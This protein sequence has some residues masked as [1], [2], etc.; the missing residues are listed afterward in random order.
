MPADFIELIISVDFSLLK[1]LQ[2]FS[3]ASSS[4]KL[5]SSSSSSF[6]QKEAKSDW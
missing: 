2:I 3:S 4:I 1:R 5:S 6:P